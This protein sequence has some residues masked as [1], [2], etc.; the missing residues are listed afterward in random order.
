MHRIDSLG[1]V[2]GF[3]AQGEGGDPNTRFT[4]EW[5][6]D[7]QESILHPIESAGITPVKGDYTQLTTAIQ[8][9]TQQDLGFRNQ[10]INPYFFFWSRYGTSRVV[11]ANQQEVVSDRWFAS[12]GDGQATITRQAHTGTLP[13]SGSSANFYRHSQTTATGAGSA[14]PFVSQRIARVPLYSN[15]TLTLSFGSKAVAGSVELTPFYRVDFGSGGGSSTDVSLPNVT[16][17]NTWQRLSSTW[18]M[19]DLSSGAYG[20]RP[21]LEVGVRMPIEATYDVDFDIFQLEIGSVV[22]PFESRE[23]NIE[24]LFGSSY[25][26]KTYDFLTVP[27][28]TTQQ[29]AVRFEQEVGVEIPGAGTH[30]PIRM[31]G[32]PTMRW[33]SPDT[34]AISRVS[35]GGSDQTVI[36]TRYTTRQYTGV[37]EVASNP[38]GNFQGSV[39]FT[40]DSEFY[41]VNP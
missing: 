13:F 10:F 31:I 14:Q 20:S 23:S 28:A 22:T 4:P 15:Q 2:L 40:A 27:G 7:V 26:Y 29:G 12:P 17:N 37:P 3:W 11:A 6:N 18:T 33:Y 35:W 16:V 21:Y 39:H 5:L 32:A 24:H 25:Y 38:G 36:D 30:L 8:T 41:A 34:G 1:N 9:L 19:P